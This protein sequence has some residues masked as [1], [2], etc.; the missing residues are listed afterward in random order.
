MWFNPSDFK[1]TAEDSTAIFAIPAIPKI[2]NSKTAKIATP[3]IVIPEIENSKIAGIANQPESNNAALSDIVS[4]PTGKILSIPDE[5]DRHQCRECLS[6]RNGYCIKQRFRP[7]DDIPRRCKDFRT[8]LEVLFES[9]KA[10][11]VQAFAVHDGLPVT[12]YTPAGTPITTLA[13]DAEH[14]EWLKRMNPPPERKAHD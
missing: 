1:K 6:L 12:V 14:A 10:E 5:D 13:R 7:V 9:H 11:I 4:T 8:G 2:Q 3:S